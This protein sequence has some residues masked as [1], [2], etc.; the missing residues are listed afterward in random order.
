ML[1]SEIIFREAI[2]SDIPKIL[3][4]YQIAPKQKK[5]K[6]IFDWINQQYGIFHV[7]ELDSRIIGGVA[8]RFPQH[9]EAWL[10]HKYI[11]PTLRKLSVGT[12][13]AIYEEAFAKRQGANVIHFATRID[14][15]PIH[16]IMGEKLGYHELSR[17]LRLK[18]L[19]PKFVQI[20]DLKK[21]YPTIDSP[22]IAMDVH[23]KYL[24]KIIKNH[25]DYY[26]SAK[27]IPYEEDLSMY[28][29]LDLKN[30]SIIQRFKNITISEKE[31]IKGIALYQTYPETKDLI[32]YQI[33]PESSEYSFLL[34]SHLCQLAH[35]N[36]WY[37]TI[38]A[39]KPHYP[40]KPF[41]SEL[42]QAK[43]GKLPLDWYVLGKKL[44]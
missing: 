18:R 42:T 34:L 2:S 28:T 1:M 24:S 40:M 11:D 23:T 35:E 37:I 12:K 17:W 8:I 5:Y 4:L 10:S 14:N 19:V 15:Y 31:K 13:M 43:P 20:E 36:K 41:L 39:A 27:L 26:S 30:P 22:T 3:E 7:A 29:Y 32:I 6:Q 33:Y 25:I 16:W 21:Y 38:L 9:G 44:K